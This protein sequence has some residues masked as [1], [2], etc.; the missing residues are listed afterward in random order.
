MPI[1][2]RFLNS[3]NFSVSEQNY[4]VLVCIFLVI[5]YKEHFGNNIILFCWNFLFLSLQRYTFKSTE[6][7][8]HDIHVLFGDVIITSV[9]HIG[10][11]TIK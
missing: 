6:C 5:E 3:S 4:K 2:L 1:L 7:R 10:V 9:A 11:L 8:R